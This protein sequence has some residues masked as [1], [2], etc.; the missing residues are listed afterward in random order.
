MANPNPVIPKKFVESQFERSDGT[1]EPLS[2]KPVQVRVP[3]SIYQV[4]EQLGEKKTPWLRRV[5]TEAAR[6][7]LLNQGGVDGANN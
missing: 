2:L 4:L 3:T 5:I 6:R 1:V 7:E